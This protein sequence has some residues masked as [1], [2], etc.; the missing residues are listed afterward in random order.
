MVKYGTIDVWTGILKF[1]NL[2]FNFFNYLKM[3]IL[4]YN[5]SAGSSFNSFCKEV[6]DLATSF[7]NVNA[8]CNAYP[9][10]VYYNVFDSLPK[11]VQNEYSLPDWK[12]NREQY[13]D[14]KKTIGS[15]HLLT[16]FKECGEQFEV[17]FTFNGR[18]IVVSVD[19][20][21]QTVTS[22]E[23][24]QEQWKKEGQ[25]IEEEWN[26]W[27]L[28]PA[29]L[30][31]TK[32]EKERE[33]KYQK[34]E[35]DFQE[36]LKVASFS[37][38][39]GG[40]EKWNKTVEVNSDGCGGGIVNYAKV[41]AYLMEKEIKEKLTKEIMDTTSSEADGEG[42]TGFMYGAA[43]SILAEC[44]KYGE[45]LRNLHNKAYGQEGEGVV[46]PAVISITV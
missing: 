38:S 12:T 39:E 37:F 21:N 1:I 46:N 9:K 44:W 18:K 19:K 7:L 45:Q 2:N 41:W 23:E 32:K 42:I 33:L 14:V 10:D 24:M 31:Y 30:E 29:G 36:A 8:H 17:H 34:K 3:K 40:E 16:F 4:N 6:H 13:R 28:T 25:R 43:V 22:I 11:E 5:P 20:T 26:Q 35:Q 27:L 15:F